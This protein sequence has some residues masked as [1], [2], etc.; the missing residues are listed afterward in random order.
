[1]HLLSNTIKRSNQTIAYHLLLALIC[2]TL[3]FQ[4]TFIPFIGEA[5]SIRN[6]S[7]NRE[8][9]IFAT[10][11]SANRL[12]LIFSICNFCSFLI[13]I[14]IAVLSD[15]IFSRKIFSYWFWFFLGVIFLFMIISYRFY[16]LDRISFYPGTLFPLS[17]L[18]Q[19]IINIFFWGILLFAM[20]KKVGCTGVIEEGELRK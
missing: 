6:N 13:S 1:M 11:A 5:Q 4:I 16:F 20:Y 14:I 9:D 19:T 8:G 18:I 10:A 12:T 17:V 2:V 3:S 7:G 15:L